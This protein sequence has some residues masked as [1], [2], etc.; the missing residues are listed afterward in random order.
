M[1]LP[2][3]DYRGVRSL[4]RYDSGGPLAVAGAEYQSVQ[5]WA[6]TL[7]VSTGIANAAYRANAAAQYDRAVAGLKAREK[8]LR[9][10]L[11]SGPVIDAEQTPLPEWVNVP[12][13]EQVV[14]QS[15]ETE[16]VPRRFFNTH[17]V[18]M[19]VYDG[20][21]QRLGDTA[22]AQTTNPLAR[23]QLEG[24]LPALQSA[25]RDAVMAKQI[26][27]MRDQNMALV[28]VAIEEQIQSLDE[29]GARAALTRAFATGLVDAKQY[30]PR[31]KAIG[32]R[33]DQTMYND[34]VLNARDVGEL[35]QVESYVASGVLPDLDPNTGRVIF[36]QSRLDPDKQMQLSRN[37]ETMRD[38]MD[39]RRS[40]K[41]DANMVQASV[42]LIEGNL[43]TRDVLELLESDDLSHQQALSLANTIRTRARE[44]PTH[45]KSNPIALSEFRGRINSLRHLDENERLETRR[46]VLEE[47]I[48]AAQTGL[49]RNG[50]EYHGVR[51]NANDAK[52]LL[53]DLNTESGR[54]AQ[55]QDYKQAKG[56]VKSYTQYSTMLTSIEG[57]EGRIRAHG[58]FMRGLDDYMDRTGADARPIEWVERNKD[59][60]NIEEYAGLNRE[61][62]MTRYPQYRH[63]AEDIDYRK[64]PEALEL[65]NRKIRQAILLDY[66]ANKIDEDT[67]RTLH[68]QWGGM[69]PDPWYDAALRED[70]R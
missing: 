69:F 50:S 15:G 11:M 21:L 38:R 19:Q 57:N 18:A 62:F 42:R 52:T 48:E 60:Y 25:H 44:T 43:R 54:T 17:E 2:G 70:V 22:L 47:D 27:Y 30:A 7:E 26:G 56:L 12:R 32:E 49:Y 31:M 68:Q 46:R 66:Y 41:H 33:I 53:A 51:L 65:L 55:R 10:L 8:G 20:T 14:N 13:V 63:L 58:D 23:A 1:K 4:G 39:E 16:Q 45:L 34:L 35:E 9:R 29:A 3:I 67:A 40:E 59:N 64:N 5:D 61:N 24:E 36:R 6:R 37:V 28:D